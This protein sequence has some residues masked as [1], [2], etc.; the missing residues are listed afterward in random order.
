MIA[1]TPVYDFQYKSKAESD[2]RIT[3]TG[4]TKTVYT[5]IVADEAPWAMHHNGRILNPI[6]TFGYTVLAIKGLLARIDNLE[7]QLA[8]KA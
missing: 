1:N 8:A 7:A 4:D 2:E 5:G 6:N 3:S